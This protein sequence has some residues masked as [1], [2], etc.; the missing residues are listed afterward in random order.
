MVVTICHVGHLSGHLI[1]WE[2]TDSG[3]ESDYS[4]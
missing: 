3:F 1:S 2:S 4:Y